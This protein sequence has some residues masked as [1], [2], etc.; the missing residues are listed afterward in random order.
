MSDRPLRDVDFD[1]TGAMTPE[2]D[3]CLLEQPPG[4]VGYGENHAFWFFDAAGK[5]HGYN[6]I[7]ALQSWYELRSERNWL[8]LPDGRV[9]YNAN[10]GTQTRKRRVGGA[11]L[12]FDCVDPFRRWSVDYLGT[13]RISSSEELAA[14]PAVEG[15]R[16]IV[17]LHLDV[18]TAAAPWTYGALSAGVDAPASK[19]IGGH[20][21]EQ[22]CRVSGRLRTDDGDDIRIEGTGV[23]THR[24]G[25]RDMHGW[26]GHCWQTA[27]FPSGRG[28]GL[29][30]IPDQDGPDG[31]AAPAWTEA[32]VLDR[33]RIVT[34]EVVEA[35]WLTDLSPRG[36][37]V[38]VRLRSRLGEHVITGEVLGNS[39]RT[40]HAA[41]APGRF[42]REFGV[43]GD[44][45]SYV[46]RQGACLWS[47]E[48]ETAPGHIEGST[49]Y[50]E[51]A[52]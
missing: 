43:W 9:L 21:Y 2:D 1:P 8:I 36:E 33:G 30:Q 24:R 27:L 10:E 23:R 37:T 20:R 28:F 45:G 17:D 11:N 26:H 15:P 29:Q 38:S 31:R 50:A 39:F 16:C 41:G 40:I 32:C 49:A 47:M 22:L 25:P 34:A 18:E 51:L 14:G 44:A 7:S 19:F 13:M 52:R 42:L 46:L 6:H 5:V 12:T 4:T 3:L 35:A 48:G